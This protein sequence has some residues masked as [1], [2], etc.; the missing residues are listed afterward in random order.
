MIFGFLVL[1]AYFLGSVPFGLLLTW[2][3][4]NFDIRTSGS[5]NIGATNVLRSGH[6]LLAFL[7]LLFDALKGA[8]SILLYGIIDHL[9]LN[10]LPSFSDFLLPHLI[11]ASAVISGH[12]FSVFLKF[13]GGKG[14]ATLGGCLFALSW[15]VGLCATS[16]WLLTFLLTKKSALAALTATLLLPL[17]SYFL[18]G[19]MFMIWSIVIGILI[20]YKHKT[21]I[22]R[23]W[24]GK[25]LGLDSRSS[26]NSS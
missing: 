5:G 20:I 9:D 1:F 2:W 16:L 26:K 13:R 23:L 8:G 10:L 24:Q 7:T 14:V 21:N 19:K 25:E 6:K 22:T 17:Y 12:I 18:S 15:P 3:G 4:A 11:L